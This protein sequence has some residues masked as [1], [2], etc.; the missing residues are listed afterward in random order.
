MTTITCLVIGDPHFK[1]NNARETAVMHERIC[2]VARERKP[3][4]IVCLGDVLDRHETIHVSP[5]ERAQSFLHDLSLIAPLY[6]LIGNHD[7][8]N[9]SNFLTSE[10]PF[11]ALK[12]WSNTKI[13]DTTYEEVI[14]GKKFLFVPYVP[15]GRLNEAIKTIV[16]NTNQN[17]N[18]ISPQE[19]N[20]TK[21][22]EENT[23]VTTAT[24]DADLVAYLSGIT[25]VFAHQEFKGAKMGAI[26]STVG[27]IWP[28]SWPYV[29]SGHIHDYDELEK[30]I[31]YVGTPIQ[32][33]F[34]DRDDK[35][36]S[37]FTWSEPAFSTELNEPYI[38]RTERIDLSMVKKIIVYLTTT[39]LATYV[40]PTDRQI[41][42]VVTGTSAEI[43]S[44]MKLANVKTLTSAGIKIVYK[45]IPTSAPLA[46]GTININ[47]V[48]P[49]IKYG[50]RLFSA[51]AGEP[52]LVEMF[53][54]LFGA[55]AA[56]APP[57]LRILPPNVETT[58]KP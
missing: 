41:K 53:T 19:M 36:V 4:F 29:I 34:G 8:P 46:N 15:P 17:I 52:D 48:G 38:P 25:T 2:D 35:T 51:C 44:A 56:P 23:T 9:N 7:R 32:H 3:T 18:Q 10:H 11:N 14:A 43:K 24:T 20:S 39:E 16:P 33:A 37:W 55:V 30:N 42:I 26:I 50:G 47:K 12:Y 27:D 40:P 28:P 5:L 58:V 1:V 45:D 54:R 21:E 22:K 57:R 49:S 31:I 13:I 6:V